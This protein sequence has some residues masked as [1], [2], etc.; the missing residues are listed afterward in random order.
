VLRQ[1]D[2]QFALRAAGR[3]RAASFTWTASTQSILAVYGRMI[4]GNS[5]YAGHGS[6]RNPD[7][8]G[9]DSHDRELEQAGGGRAPVRL[10][11]VDYG[12]E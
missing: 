12:P 8:R 4:D 5:D 3:E 2:K 1:R 11:G 9:R 7:K 10:P 6:D